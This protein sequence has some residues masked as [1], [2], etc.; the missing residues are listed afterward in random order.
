[1]STAG[2]LDRTADSHVQVVVLIVILISGTLGSARGFGLSIHFDSWLCQALDQSVSVSPEARDLGVGDPSKPTE[3]SDNHISSVLGDSGRCR[4]AS[5]EDLCLEG[6]VD[7]QGVDLWLCRKAV[8]D[9]ADGLLPLRE[10]HAQVLL[11]NNVDVE[12]GRVLVKG[13]A[14]FLNRGRVDEDLRA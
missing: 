9:G 3:G 14:A 2:L 8:D 12:V 11:D 1:M 4:L 5:G 10:A 7:D 13:G 6:N